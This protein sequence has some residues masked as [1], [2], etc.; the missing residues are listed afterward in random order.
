MGNWFEKDGPCSRWHSWLDA[1]SD[2]GAPARDLQQLMARISA[3]DRAHFLV[4]D[5]CRIAAET[6]LGVR[7][8]LQGL[9]E[10]ASPAPPWFAGRVMAAIAEREEETR[11]AAAWIAV[12]RFASRLAWAAAALLLA[13]STW[14]YEKPLARPAAPPS[15]SASEG[16]FDTQA[17][18]VTEDEVLISLAEK[19]HE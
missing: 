11:P 6:W 8:S 7:E 18:P 16:I 1:G 19:D 15:A 13:A 17:P 3:A 12:P 9:S 10:A 14:L 5:D 4:C 2:A